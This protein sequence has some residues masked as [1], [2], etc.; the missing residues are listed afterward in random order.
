M[1]TGLSY[2]VGSFLMPKFSKM[3]GCGLLALV[4]I[5]FF[6]GCKMEVVT[7][8]MIND[9]LFIKQKNQSLFL[10]VAGDI[11]SRKLLLIVHGG[12][13]GNSLDY[14]DSMIKAVI[15]PNMAVGYWDQRFGGNSQ[16]NA[17]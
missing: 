17:G 15:E 9:D 5:L 11:G 14:R 8:G 1:Y 16:G 2:R 12:P 3:S 7:D 10:K 13:G 4:A 6:S